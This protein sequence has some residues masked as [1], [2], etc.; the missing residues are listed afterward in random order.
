MNPLF[1]AADGTAAAADALVVVQRS[2]GGS[3][4]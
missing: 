1:V 4:S 3:E 2:A